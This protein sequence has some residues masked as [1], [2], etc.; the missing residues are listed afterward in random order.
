M[1]LTRRDLMKATAAVAGA[2]G[3]HASGLVKL[4]EAFGLEASAGGVSVVW[5][6]AQSCTGCSVSLLNSIYYTTVDDLL[7]N[8]LDL[9]FHPTM[10]AAA[11]E[12]AVGAAEEAY[13]KGDYILVVEGAIPIYE[14][15]A[16]C[17]LWPGTTALAGV[18][19]FATKANF[20][21]GVGTCACYG[22][23]IAGAPNPTGARGLGMRFARKRV[24]NIPGCPAHPDW[25]VGTI[26][27]LMTYGQPPE[28]DKYGRPKEFFEKKIHGELCPYK[29]QQETRVLGEG[30]CLKALGC[31][32]PKTKADCHLRLW[33]A[34]GLDQVGVNWC[35]GSGAPCI[36]CTEPTFPDGMSPFYK[37][38]R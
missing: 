11:G 35:M 37:L 22:G 18:R 8:S 27:Y 9:D 38:A 7:L 12:L 21:L 19:R 24:I 10:M 36:G 33:N 15:G 2:M 25:I 6:Q 29:G 5:L 32:G 1:E 20:I 13:Q 16:Y 26:A 28:L 30:G 34:G 14:R 3:L 23:V 17:T 4:Q 31:K